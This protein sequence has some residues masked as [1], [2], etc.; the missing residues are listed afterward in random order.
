MDT[1]TLCE[2]INNNTSINN[3]LSKITS[4]Y[5]IFK[6]H[7]FIDQL[8]KVTIDILDSLNEF[9]NEFY[10]YKK[11]NDHWMLIPEMIPFDH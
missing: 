2:I 8:K 1:T 3:Y 5:T 9:P 11:F 10:F 6:P 4:K 7:P